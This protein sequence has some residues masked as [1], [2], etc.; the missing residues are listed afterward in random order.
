MKLCTNVRFN[1]KNKKQSLSMQLFCYRIKV[2]GQTWLLFD[3]G[4]IFEQ[5]DYIYMDSS[6][7]AGAVSIC[8]DIEGC[9]LSQRR[10]IDKQFWFQTCRKWLAL[11]IWWAPHSLLLEVAESS[12]SSSSRFFSECSGGET[13]CPFLHE[14]RLA[15]RCDSVSGS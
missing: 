2:V 4:H 12:V 1:A 7:T 10:S 6:S 9:R 13:V 3:F 11:R 8:R 14:A 5:L 15:D